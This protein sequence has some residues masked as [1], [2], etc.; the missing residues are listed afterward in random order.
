VFR[1]KYKGMIKKKYRHNI[2]FAQQYKKAKSTTEHKWSR[3]DSNCTGW[4]THKAMASFCPFL[5]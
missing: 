2:Y 3:L 5:R 4:E 1:I